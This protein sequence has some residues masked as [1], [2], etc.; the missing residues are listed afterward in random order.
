MECAGAYVVFD[1]VGSLVTQ[2]FGLGICEELSA[3]SLDKIEQFFLERGAQVDHEVCPLAGVAALNLLCE[4]GYKPIEISNVLYQ[5]VQKSES[6][7]E[8]KISVHAIL[9]N[10]AK[11]WTEINAKG[12][13]HE[14]PELIDFMMEMGAMCTAR[15]GSPC[16]L[17][18][19]EGQP[20]AVGVLSIHE[21]VALFAGATTIPELRRRGLQSALLAARM[22][23][24]FEHGCDLAMMVAEAGSNSQRNAERQ[25]FRV[26]YTRTKW[27]LA[28]H[29][30]CK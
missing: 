2:T 5:P 4:R 19:F 7:V 21:G 16:F 18:E 27:R 8:P 20:G 29:L 9:P 11:L 12:W 28:R 17:A 10:E 23:Y 24:A 15:E 1:G 22:Q 30:D 25:G 14:L 26:A 3:A 13:G 6:A